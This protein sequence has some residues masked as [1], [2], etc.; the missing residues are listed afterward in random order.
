MVL[1]SRGPGGEFEAPSP[2]TSWLKA[3]KDDWAAF[4]GSDRAA[5]LTGVTLPGLRRL[6]EMRDL[7]RRAWARYKRQPYV[8]GSQGQP[9]AN[10]GFDEATKLERAIVALEDRYGLS[11]KALANLGVALGQAT[12]TAQELNT[13]AAARVASDDDDPD[14]TPV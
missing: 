6:F 9:V 2:S 14:W 1:A 13:L 8:D 12:L 10:P 3:T 11:L 4:F 7:Q 5:V